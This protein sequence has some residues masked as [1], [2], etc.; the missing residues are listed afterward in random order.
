MAKEEKKP[1]PPAWPKSLELVQSE[2][3]PVVEV[4]EIACVRRNGAYAVEVRRT[5]NGKPEAEVVRSSTDKR[6]A[7]DKALAAILEAWR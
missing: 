2:Q 6:I 4:M 3:K 7:A 5:V 1:G